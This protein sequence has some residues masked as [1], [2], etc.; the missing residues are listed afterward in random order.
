[1]NLNAQE[2]QAVEHAK[3]ELVNE[4]ATFFAPVSS[5]V[6]DELLGQYQA[7]KRSIEQLAEALLGEEFRTAMS[8]FLEASEIRG[9]HYLS[10]SSLA[11]V[12]AALAV[13][14]ASYWSK[15]LA[16]TDVLDCMPQSRRD[17]WNKAIADRKTVPFTEDAVRPTIADLLA[18]RHKYF[19]E[20]VDGIFRGLSGTHATNEP[21]GFS[22]RMILNYVLSDGYPNHSRA[23]LINDL[24]SVIATFMGRPGLK[25]YETGNLLRR[26]AEG[27]EWGEW[28]DV[29]GGAVRIRIYR[30]FGTAHLEINPEVAYR[31]NNVL[32]SLYPMAIPAKFRSR[33]KRC[34]VLIGRKTSTCSR[35][36]ASAAWLACCLS[37]GPR[38]SRSR[39]WGAMF[40]ARAAP[41]AQ[42]GL[43]RMGGRSARSR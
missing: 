24:R 21:Q 2:L 37:T 10:L 26:L 4:S 25:H 22:K 20:R 31:L 23:G 9:G 42:G 39:A 40:C 38:A 34:S 36:P 16:L 6:L 12:D 35:A 15:A 5:D 11:N 8:Y 3:A 32:A 18:S 33:P 28:H 17:E 19:C 30:G 14:D 7:R 13:L 29:D 41:R 27:R 1:M 43:Y